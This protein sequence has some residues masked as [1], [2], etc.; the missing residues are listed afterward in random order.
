MSLVESGQSSGPLS[1]DAFDPTEMYCEPGS[2]YIVKSGR[3]PCTRVL[4]SKNEDLATGAR[5]KALPTLNDTRAR[6]A[7]DAHMATKGRIPRMHIEP[8][9]VRGIVRGNRHAYD[10]LAEHGSA[11]L[12]VTSAVR[13]HV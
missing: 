1:L 6:T 9:I 5:T 3:S 11:Q 13:S 12:L 2:A 8:S 4:I 7:A 10:C